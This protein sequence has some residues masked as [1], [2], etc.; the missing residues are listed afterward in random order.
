MKA[1]TP[2]LLDEFTASEERR[3]ASGY[4]AEAF[5]EAILSGIEAQ[6]LAHAALSAALHELVGVHGED[7][8]ARFA[9]SLPERIRHGE[10]S[11]F[12][13]H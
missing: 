8:V 6:N 13:T 4:V 11:L 7:A 2:I 9:E 12:S 5:A 3:E 10:F 1:D